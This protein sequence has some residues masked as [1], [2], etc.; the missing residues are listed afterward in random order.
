MIWPD[1]RRAVASQPR[2][3]TKRSPCWAA[4]EAANA[5]RRC[6]KSGAR[7]PVPRFSGNPR[8]GSETA[9]ADAPDRRL[10]GTRGDA[11]KLL[12]TFPKSGA[13]EPSLRFS[14]NPRLGS[15]TA[16]AD[17]P[18]RR[19]FGTR[20]DAVKLLLTFPKSGAQDCVPARRDTWLV[21]E[22]PNILHADLDAFYASV[23]QLL[24]PSLRGKPV[25][26]GG[27]IVVAA[28]YEAK[29]MGVSPPMN[30]RTALALC[31][32]A[33]VVNGSFDQYLDLSRRVMDVCRDFT[34]HLEQ[35]SIDEAFLDVSGSVHLFGSAPTMA[36]EIRRRV[37]QEVGLPISVGVAR[38]KFLAKVAS[39]QA[40]P[41]GVLV[42][43]P[44]TETEWLHALPV[45]VMWGVGPVT[46]AR[47]HDRGIV[48]VGQLAE[49]SEAS[50]AHWLG[51]GI[52]RH[53]HAL[54]W[55][56]DPRS[57]VTERR[58]GSVGAQSA[59]GR[60]HS[61]LGDLGQ[62]L[63]R[64]ADRVSSRLRA[65]NRAG[66]TLTVR[67]RYDDMS[68]ASRAVT[69]PAAVASTAALHHAG[70]PL[71]ADAQGRPGRTLTLVGIAVSKLEIGGPLQMELPFD[72]GDPV[73]AGS[74]IGAAHLLVDRKVDLARERFGRD[75]VGRAS[76]LLGK[77]GGM[78]D[79][80][81][82]LAERS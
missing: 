45:R 56:R 46:E 48:T 80:F 3:R 23:E 43:D 44:P 74:K 37:K 13:R 68:R 6:S 60:G 2:W 19:L 59:L 81:R 31:P 41:D 21:G 1:R 7:E 10:F 53:F 16:T 71:L 28:S 82:E 47:L 78:P 33:I 9:T 72:D 24:N 25:L 26:V 20:G 12:L 55:N 66:R 77:K 18:D 61:D 38:T 69:L 58:A 15:E 29:A 52:G 40:K 54:S 67:V 51:P 49:A 64:L 75:A 34:P 79:E 62:V 70:L 30:V 32:K 36:A 63:L 57:V 22:V 42:V 76:V 5:P 50:L 4:W 8:L 65:K 73:R 11:V 17:A 14:G 27:G 35:I 39:G